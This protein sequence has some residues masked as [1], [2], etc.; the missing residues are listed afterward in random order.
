MGRIGES[1]QTEDSGTHTLIC[2]STPFVRSQK[3]ICHPLPLPFLL[4]ATDE[5]TPPS[6]SDTLRR[7][8]RNLPFV[9]RGDAI[10]TST[11]RTRLFFCFP[12]NMAWT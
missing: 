12:E 11:N 4:R 3:W 9:L 5:A 8:T 1:L 7:N 2:L 10:Y 6:S